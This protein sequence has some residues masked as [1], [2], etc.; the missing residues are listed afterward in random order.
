[1]PLGNA[2]LVDGQQ[3]L[4]SDRV[5]SLRM[6]ADAFVRKDLSPEHPITKMW[7]PIDKF[8][9][10]VSAALERL[11]NLKPDDVRTHYT[12]T[13]GWFQKQIRR[14]RAAHQELKRLADRIVLDGPRMGRVEF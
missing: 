8:D 2:F 9:Q 7:E 5:K 10:D 13:M 1:M 11:Q 4:L 6:W 3:K 14:M 12:A